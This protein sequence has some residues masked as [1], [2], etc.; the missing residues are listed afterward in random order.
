MWLSQ[1]LLQSNNDGL[2][3]RV[4][5]HTRNKAKNNYHK[6][7]GW[8]CISALLQDLLC[9]ELNTQ[10]SEPGVCVPETDLCSC[11]LA[12]PTFLLIMWWRM[13]KSNSVEFLL[14][15]SSILNTLLGRE[16]SGN[17]YFCNCMSEIFF[18][19]KYLM[20]SIYFA[21]YDLIYVIFASI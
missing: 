14:K 8:L 7:L 5:K 13:F 6:Y 18:Y 21:N 2:I 9:L 3:K 16:V 1:L 15:T 17:C 10:V 12:L 20:S 4:R 19:T 11:N